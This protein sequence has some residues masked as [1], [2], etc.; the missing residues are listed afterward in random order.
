MLALTEARRAAVRC[1]RTLSSV[2]FP[3]PLLESVTDHGYLKLTSDIRWAHQRQQL[4]SLNDTI[5]IVQDGL[6]LL[7]LSILHCDCDAL[8]PKAADVRV[9][10]L[11][12]VA[13][14]HLFNVRHFAIAA[15]VELATSWDVLSHVG[16]LQSLRFR[17]IRSRRQTYARN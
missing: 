9:G 3:E 4:T 7:C 10:E 8:P 12:I 15:A 2:V 13:A 11:G 14:N 5:N 17:S 6:W 16:G 1:A